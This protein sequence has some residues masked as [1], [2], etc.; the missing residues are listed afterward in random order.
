[1][2]VNHL[3]LIRRRRNLLKKSMHWSR[4]QEEDHRGDFG[5]APPAPRYTY[6]FTKRNQARERISAVQA[7]EYRAFD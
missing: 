4:S 1:M 5:D 2:A 6:R 7:Y 3:Y